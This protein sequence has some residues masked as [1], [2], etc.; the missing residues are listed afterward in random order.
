[1]PKRLRLGDTVVIRAV[2][3]SSRLYHITG[4][5]DEVTCY[6]GR[7]PEDTSLA[8]MCRF[9]QRV[10]PSFAGLVRGVYEVL[11]WRRVGRLW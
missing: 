6:A 2:S 3:P 8:F 9:V 1:M 10:V 11:R 4:F 5:R 7:L